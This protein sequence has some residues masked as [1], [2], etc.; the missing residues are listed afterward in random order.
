MTDTLATRQGRSP[1]ELF[2]RMLAG[3]TIDFAEVGIPP[4]ATLLARAEAEGVVAL[5]N[6]RMARM[7]H[8]PPGFEEEMAARARALAAASLLRQAECGRILQVLADIPVLVLK[9]LALGA[10]LYPQPYFRES[11]D[12][13]LLFSSRDDTIQAAMRLSAHGYETCFIPGELA[14]EL[15]CRRST[16]PMPIDLDLHWRISGMPMFFNALTFRELQE[17]S[18]QLPLPGMNARG[19]SPVHALTH[20]C[21]HRASNIDS[22]IGDRLKWLYD[23]HLLAE[24]FKKGDWKEL[25]KLCEVRKL[26]GIVFDGISACR[27]AFSSPIPND[28]LSALSAGAASESLDVSRLSDWRYI[29]GR[30]FKALPTWSSRLRWLAHRLFP[31]TGYLHELYG[32]DM[33]GAALWLTRSRRAMK[34]ISGR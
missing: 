18:I 32:R 6:Q 33:D 28:F 15:L 29:Q 22:G 16:G 26:C 5:L 8:L 27:K 30:N 25:Q 13:D 2:A 31:E 21:I 34:R 17:D 12:I 11:S 4:V 24:R 3:Q 19:L 14:H 20:A 10:W 23:L 9:G 7:R 1:R